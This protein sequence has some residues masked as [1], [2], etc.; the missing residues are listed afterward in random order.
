M[1][2]L[3][4]SV[5]LIALLL[6]SSR[7]FTQISESVD[8]L[9]WKDTR[10][11]ILSQDYLK[12]LGKLSE[13]EKNAL[14][15]EDQDLL[16]FAKS[17]LNLKTQN[18]KAAIFGFETYIVQKGRLRSYAHFYLGEYYFNNNNYKKAKLH[19]NKS[20]ALK[21]P[22][23]IKYKI[24]EYL[25]EIY[26]E[27]KSFKS[28]F[29]KFNY[30]ER[31]HRGEIKHPDLVWKMLEVELGRKRKWKACKWLKKIYS[32]YPLE[33]S[34]S[35]WDM[36]LK[37]IKVFGQNPNCLASIEDKKKRIRRLQW[38]GHAPRAREELDKLI[39]KSAKKSSYAGDYLL[40]NYLINEGYVS[41]ALKLLLS[42]Y[43]SHAKNSKYLGLL[44]K[45]AAR[46]E[47]YQLAS[48]S[49]Y[50]IYQNNP[51]SNVG[52]NGL[53][54]SAFLDYTFQDYDSAHS[55]FSKFINT[56]RK[57]KLLVDVHWYKSW[58]SYLREDF[59][60]AAKGFKYI[61]SQKKRRRRRYIW[62]NIP[63]D[64]LKYWLAK[65]YYKKN[66]LLKAEKIFK[67][68]SE[69]NLLSYYSYL[70]KTH[71]KIIAPKIKAYTD[72]INKSA[73]QIMTREISSYGGYASIVRMQRDDYVNDLNAIERDRLKEAD[74]D[75]EEAEE[76]A[77]ESLFSGL[78]E[79]KDVELDEAI[80]VTSKKSRKIKSR[81][82]QAKEL[83]L[84]GLYDLALWELYEIERRTSNP[85]YL[86]ALIFAYKKIG[87]YHR[88]SYISQVYFSKE[89]E[90][91]G[92]KGRPELWSFSYPEA[93]KQ[94]VEKISNDFQ[95]PKEFIWGIMKAESNYK[96]DI[97]SA[98]GAKGLMQL[99]PFTAKKVAEMLQLKGFEVEKLILPK[100]NILLGTR[101]LKRLGSEFHS[102][103]LMA[104]SYNAGP[105]RVKLWTRH[106]GR[107]D[108]DEFIE[109]IPYSETR[110]YVKKVMRYYGIYNEIYGK[111]KMSLNQLVEPNEYS[112]NGQLVHREIW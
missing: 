5:L 63:E 16:L 84:V 98:V 59:D 81:F 68:L 64:K 1:L 92:Y 18:N 15:K 73:D 71:L 45:A 106:F 94:Y 105:H 76:E 74:E 24:K 4:K 39:K 26:L 48:H 21:P 31:K 37:N 103:P 52:R 30:L 77:K 10:S 95:V 78:F 6:S 42:Y 46:S 65:S 96:K 20:D 13:K 7:A 50:L 32:K 49:Y 28:A 14:K 22:R 108:R 112:P 85:Q 100:I 47:K 79:D 66:E 75:I 38:S 9:P 102:L 12:A 90:K 111:N 8:E 67:K 44:A 57:T 107:L 104:A 97:Q 101:Y 83:L 34:A 99:M 2:S 70:S 19:L 41:D 55:K 72:N 54:Q 93:Y 23:N 56:Y 89:R 43:D 17:V 33:E 110:N 80:K 91:Y 53:F 109:H 29:K 25:G 27:K 61:L 51:K 40:A 88:S 35:Y 82:K 36:D 3:Q 62:R 69:D 60:G 87:A 86:R 11:L 58:V